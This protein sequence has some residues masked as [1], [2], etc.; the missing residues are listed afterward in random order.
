MDS[1][2]RQLDFEEKFKTKSVKKL[3]AIAQ[4]EYTKCLRGDEAKLKAALRVR[5]NKLNE[6]FEWTVENKERLLLLN[7]KLMDGFEQL[8]TEVTEVQRI[9]QKRKDGNDEFLQYYDIEASIRPVFHDAE[10]ESTAKILED[11]WNEWYLNFSVYP[12]E[13]LDNNVLYFDYE[14]NWND[15]TLHLMGHFDEH[16]ISYG[17]HDLFDH[18][19]EWSCSDILKI[20]TLWVEY[21]VTCRHLEEKF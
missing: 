12:N 9:L 8:R 11:V 16:Y 13:S 5:A 20:N 21:K 3:E 7:K 19:Y 1:W 14:T 17:I 2:R 4:E 6:T 15:V 10:D 18:I